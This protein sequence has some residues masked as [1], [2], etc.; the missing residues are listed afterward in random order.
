MSRISKIGIRLF[1]CI[2]CC[3]SLTQVSAQS[4]LLNTDNFSFNGGEEL[5]G[6]ETDPP[7]S[8]G[9]VPVDGGLSLLLAAGTALGY[10]QL[11]NRKS[12]DRSKA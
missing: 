11:R 8:M 7:P 6:S 2:I 12:N 1:A 4:S 10:R 3:L 9:D 5:L